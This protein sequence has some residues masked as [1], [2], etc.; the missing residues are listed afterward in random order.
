MLVAN[1]KEFRTASGFS[2]ALII[3]D[4]SSNSNQPA[5][6]GSRWVD[7]LPDSEPVEVPACPPLRFI[8]NI[9][10]CTSEGW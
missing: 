9:L 10:L 4:M 2:T 8:R 5:D 7:R 1:E 3:K 6:K